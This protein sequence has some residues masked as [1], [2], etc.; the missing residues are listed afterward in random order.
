[1]TVIFFSLG[2]VFG[3]FGINS[4]NPHD[5]QDLSNFFQNFVGSLGSLNFSS[6]N[7]VQQTVFNHLKIIFLI[8]FLG[9]TVI[10]VP[11]ILII[12]FIK[13][14]VTGFTVG[15][16]IHEKV[17]GGLIFALLAVLPSN[18]LLIPVF[19]VAAVSALSFSLGLIKGKLKNGWGGISQFMISYCALMLLLASITVFGGL[20]EAYIIPPIV[21]IVIGYY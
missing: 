2:I 14:F 9:L 21:E 8:W 6:L 13:G 12:M 16:I 17:H 20:I 4:L 18:I 11:I 5:Y 15:F 3:A 19:I 7:L 1:V 10:G